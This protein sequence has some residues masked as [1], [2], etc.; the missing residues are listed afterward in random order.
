MAEK[1][2]YNFDHL[3]AISSG[4]KDCAGIANSTI[5]LAATAQ[6]TFYNNYEGQGKD[7]ANEAFTKIAEHLDLI[8]SC[9]G[10]AG[11]YVSMV[12]TE[13]QKMDAELIPNP[14]E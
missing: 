11:E 6:S 14:E 7:I 5:T 10:L 3:S 8:K 9:L 13:M 1:Q 2:A 12:L 4:Y